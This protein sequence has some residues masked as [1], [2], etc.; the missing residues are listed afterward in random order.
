M[1]TFFKPYVGANY[2][3]TRLLIL[4][5]SHYCNKQCRDCGLC[6]VHP[7]CANF[8]TT[9]V[10]D[11][12]NPN[13][14]REGWMN[15]YLKFE[16]SLVGHVTNIAE[17]HQIWENLSFY[18]YLQVPM[19]APRQ[20]GTKEQ[21]R[22]SEDAFFSVLEALKPQLMIV[23]GKRL[24]HHLPYTYWRDSE[25]LFIRSV[26]QNHEEVGCYT[27]PSGQVIPAIGVYHPSVGYAWSF[28][29]DVIDTMCNKLN[30]R[31]Q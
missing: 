7:E 13:N 12:L 23:W 31:N 27:L 24:W 5:E 3:K 19:S 6:G 28:W 20:A 22:Q 16:R 2:A 29:H 11:Y 21:Y 26:S 25:S 4:G 1:Q 9:V 30:K 18:N 14:E 8:T 10:N 17:S 15:T